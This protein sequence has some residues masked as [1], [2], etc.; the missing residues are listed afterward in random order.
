MTKRVSTIIKNKLP[1]ILL[2]VFIDLVFLFLTS[3]IAVWARH[4]FG[5]IPEPYL[6]NS[7]QYLIIDFILLFILFSIFKLYT[8]VW[9]YASVTELCD[10]I[11]AC[12]IYE[13]TAYVYKALF[14]ISL[15]RSYC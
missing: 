9:K 5:M 10:I 3:F 2:F 1:N 8:S 7:Y 13:T 4:D 12:C 11:L 6:T 15:P 14:A